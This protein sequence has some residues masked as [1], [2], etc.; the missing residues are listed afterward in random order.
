MKSKPLPDG[1]GQGA[2]G[3]GIRVWEADRIGLRA[4]GN[5]RKRHPLPGGE[6]PWLQM[7][8]WI[9][10]EALGA[11]TRGG[12]PRVWEKKPRASCT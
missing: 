7:V 6:G 2:V 12:A 8:P 4:V 9:K 11:R 10:Q 1:D 5:G 3:E